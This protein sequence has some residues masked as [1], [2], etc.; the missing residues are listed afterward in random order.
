MRLVDKRYAGTAL[1]VGQAKIIGRIHAIDMQIANKVWNN[2]ILRKFFIC[3]FVTCSLTILD[4]DKI[5]FLFGLD[6]LKRHEVL[7]F[8]KIPKS[9][10]K[11]I[12]V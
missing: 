12:P 9:Y 8:L 1:G 6:M 11:T 2:K 4:D 10:I 3:K 5:D 7:K